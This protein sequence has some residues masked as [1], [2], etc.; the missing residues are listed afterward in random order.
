MEKQLVICCKTY[1]HCCY[2]DNLL[3]TQSFQIYLNVCCFKLIALKW[4]YD[5]VLYGIMDEMKEQFI[6]FFL[7]WAKV[8][9]YFFSVV[10]CE[11]FGFLEMIF[12][13]N[14]ILVSS[15]NAGV[16]RVISF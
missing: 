14:N 13:F 3:S 1:D 10:L 8:L 2:L 6:Y 5:H 9:F 4:S 12:V 15:H 7:Y 11:V 16:F